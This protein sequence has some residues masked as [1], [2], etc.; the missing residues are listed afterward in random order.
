MPYISKTY[1]EPIVSMFFEARLWFDKSGC[2][3]YHSVRIF[4]N[5]KMLGTTGMM[6]GSETQYQYETVTKLVELE[7][8]PPDVS[9]LPVWRIA[10]IY[11][12]HI[13]TSATFGKRS[14]M[15]RQNLEESTGIS[16]E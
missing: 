15:F 5:G 9:G 6:Y 8:L 10:N 14:E 7:I 3:T 4:I 1:P 12:I 2:N 16:N 11:G 13:Y